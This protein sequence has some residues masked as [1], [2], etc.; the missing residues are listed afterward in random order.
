MNKINKI[1]TK[2]RFK[3]KIKDNKLSK[4]HQKNRTQNK[5]KRI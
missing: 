1:L 5:M 4:A 3:L 2:I